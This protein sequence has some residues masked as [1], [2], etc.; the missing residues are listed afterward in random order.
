MLRLL[1]PIFLVLFTVVLGQDQDLD[2]DPWQIGYQIKRDQRR[3]HLEWEGKEHCDFA[4]KLSHHLAQKFPNITCVVQSYDPVST[5]DKHA[6]RYYNPYGSALFREGK[7]NSLVDCREKD[8][9]TANFAKLGKQSLDRIAKKSK[10]ASSNYA[11]SL[12]EKVENEVNMN[13]LSSTTISVIGADAKSCFVAPTDQIVTASKTVYSCITKL[14]WIKR[15]H[16][17]KVLIFG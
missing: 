1:L 11:L 12:N 8:E 2:L 14:C 6:L 4:K 3:Y 15:Y 9:L 7:R 10:V 17:F 13:D 16:S 5:Y